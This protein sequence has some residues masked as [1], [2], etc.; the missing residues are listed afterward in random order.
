M[1]YDHLS[2]RSR[3]VAGQGVAERIAYLNDLPYFPVKPL[4]QVENWLKDAISAHVGRPLKPI[5]FL[6]T[7]SGMGAGTMINRVQAAFPA[8]P[9]QDQRIHCYPA[10]VAHVPATASINEIGAEVC[11]FVGAPS[12]C[13]GGTSPN[14]TGWLKLLDQIGTRML[15]LKDMHALSCLSKTDRGRLLNFIRHATSRY[16]LQV[17]LVGPPDL[18]PLVMNDPQLADRAQLIEVQ[19]FKASDQALTSFLEAFLMW[20]PLRYTSDV[21]DDH[22]LRKL[23][24]R[25]TNGTT[26]NMLDV[27]TR[28]GAFAIYSAEERITYDLWRDY[29]SRAEYD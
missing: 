25:R 2:P 22:S 12:H 29:F 9:Q 16:E 7:P 5:T 19:P 18:H 27:L 4:D 21:C 11:D 6:L 15:I 3:V 14:S 17:T 23:L 1:T 28:L 20:V 8:S 13:I 24:V 26:R 10:V